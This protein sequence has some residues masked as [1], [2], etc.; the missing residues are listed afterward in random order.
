VRDKAL[1]PL[2][3]FLVKAYGLQ[4]INPPA[5]H[6]TLDSPF[7]DGVNVLPFQ[8]EKLTS[9]VHRSTRFNHLDHHR[10]KGRSEPTVR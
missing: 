9:G 8:I 7:H 6:S 2:K 5:P 4:S 1:S 3:A 10:L